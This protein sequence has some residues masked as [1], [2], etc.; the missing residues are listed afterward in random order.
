[1]VNEKE[2]SS[3]ELN[4]MRRYLVWCYKTT[5]EMADK[6]DRYFTQSLVDQQILDELK[7]SDVYQSELK[8]DKVYKHYVDDFEAYMGKKLNSAKKKKYISGEGSQI[9][10]EYLYLKNRL[11]SIKKT[12]V[13]ML[14]EKALELIEVSYEAE[15][16]QR[17]LQ[18]RDHS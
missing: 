3:D 6:I 10:P 2:L 7:E 4:L 1:M 5:K 15:M 16:T 13:N 8:Q 11:Q 12:I 14:G 18:A 9:D 17:I